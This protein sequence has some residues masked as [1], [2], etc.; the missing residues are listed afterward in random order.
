[1]GLMGKGQRVTLAE[2][3]GCPTPEATDTWKPISHF[4]L[5]TAVRES[6]SGAGYNIVQEDF[7]L[8][9]KARNRLFGVFVTDR[10]DS[11]DESR[12]MVGF[13]HS[14]DKSMAV[15]LTVGVNVIV[16]SNMAFGGDCVLKHKHSVNFDLRRSLDT[17]LGLMET[18][19]SLMAERVDGL[20]RQELSLTAAKELVV[21]AAAAGAIASCDIMPVLDEYQKPTFPRFQPGN[22]W[23][24]Y[25]SF[26]YIAQKFPVT[27]LDE[28]LRTLATP[29]FFN[30]GET[31]EVAAQ[32]V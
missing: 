10:C 20:K 18:R 3:Q 12:R 32:A 16:C 19:W 25:N 13:R 21:D 24:L 9:D 11:G 31:V 8:G 22:R 4:E 2:L 6:V 1:M 14:N 26:T 28:C 23:S 27:K 15:S 30:L 5:A 17:M 7:L 29:K